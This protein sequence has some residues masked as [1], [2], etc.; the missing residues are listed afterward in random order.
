[1]LALEREWLASGLPVAALMET[2][3]QRMA[4]WFLD[5]EELLSSGVVVLVGPGHNGGDGL[6]VARKL[7]EANVDVRVWAP[8]PLRQALTQEHWRHL[9]WLGA[10]VLPS[11][12]DPA[13]RDLWIEALFGL[14]QTR[15]LPVD[16]ADL[17]SRRQRD[18][19]GR[20]VS[21]DVPAGL[22]SDTGCPMQGGAAFAAHTLCVGLIKCGLVQDAALA[23][24][25]SLQRI[26]PAVPLS[27]TQSLSS[28]AK[29]RVLADDIASLP[30][31]AEAAGATKYQR[32]RLLLVAG[33]DR[34][35]GAAHLVVRGAL[36]S[37][38]G[39]VEACLPETVAESLWQQAPEVVVGAGLSCDGHGALLWGEALAGRDLARLDAVLVGPGLGMVKGCWQQ[40]A[41]PLLAFPGLLV[42]DA[43]GLNQ[44]AFAEEGWRWLL[45]RS[46]PTWI[47]PHHGE[48]ERLFPECQQRSPLEMASAAADRCGAVVLLKGAHT[49]IASPSGDVMQLTDT[50]PAVART[51]LGDLLAGHCAGWG[52]RCLAA[53]HKAGFED[54]TASAYLH[55]SAARQCIRG[56]DATAISEQLASLTRFVLRT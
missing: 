33:S 41:D 39:S 3:G 14:G 31:P 43:D 5:R 49:V 21:L 45:N 25:G 24:V 56:S 2:V 53:T 16:L 6:V 29:L 47:T 52:A 51:G 40:W 10:S 18:S 27:L 15:P 17:F 11:S 12:P 26:D 37:G 20:L 19:P 35:R 32:G 38:A 44:L 9:I 50:D 28:P 8:M 1:M 23:H 22:D 54:L 36:A 13:G 42:L 7:L 55:A 34:Y 48:F 46:G 4:D 30:S